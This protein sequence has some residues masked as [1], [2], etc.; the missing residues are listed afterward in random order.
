MSHIFISYSKKNQP[1]ARKLAKKLKQEGFNIWID[2]RI[3]Y[4][5]NW[6]NTIFTAIDDCAVILP[7]MSL[8]SAESMWVQRECHHAEKRGKPAFPVLLSGEEFPRYGL[9]QYADVRGSVLPDEDFYELIAEHLPRT[10]QD[11]E[12]V[13]P[14]Q[15]AT[16]EMPRH[17]P[18]NDSG[19][20]AKPAP[21]SASKVASEVTAPPPP[22]ST[23]QGR[24][25]IAIAIFALLVA[26]GLAFALGDTTGDD[27]DNN[28][29]DA[30]TFLSNGL[31]H[32]EAG[33]YEVAIGEFT[34]AID[35]DPDNEEFYF[36]RGIAHINNGSDQ[37]GQDDLQ[38]YLDHADDINPDAY[39]WVA[40]AA[41]NL[42]DNDTAISNLESALSYDYSNWEYHLEL[43]NAYYNVHDYDHA[44]NAYSI[45]VELVNGEN[46][47]DEIFQ[48]IEELEDM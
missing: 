20:V 21:V 24:L 9:T 31:F 2:D 25:A 30:S 41:M 46:V 35:V 18:T 13:T 16:Q 34:S 7:I 3:E 45:Y 19:V 10:M 27:G 22:S 26:G 44:L 47:P 38:H 6:E 14:P 1:Y 33:D 43:G 11:G 5:V 39:Y 42:E 8:E 28:N 4:G 37:V 36:H 15:L 40:I 32:L 29:G 12:D 48:R 17:V 23:T